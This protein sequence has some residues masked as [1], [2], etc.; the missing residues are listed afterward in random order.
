MKQDFKEWLEHNKIFFEI[1]VA[2]ALS[3]M[4]IF[5]SIQSNII[6]KSQ[7]RTMEKEKLPYIEIKQKKN[8]EFFNEI[9]LVNNEE[10]G[11]PDEIAIYNRGGKLLDFTCF[12]IFGLNTHEKYYGN[13]KKFNLSDYID[14]RGTLTGE[15]EGLIC[16]LMSKYDS[17]ADWLEDTLSKHKLYMYLSAAFIIRYTDVFGNDHKEYWILHSSRHVFKTYQE[18]YAKYLT[19]IIDSDTISFSKDSLKKLIPII[20]QKNQKD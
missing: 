7:I 5:L 2:T 8:N 19:K 10:G 3:F 11:L 13:Y 16:T 6:A 12:S 14:N 20:I 15:S 17:T 1:L 4:A 9:D 18:E